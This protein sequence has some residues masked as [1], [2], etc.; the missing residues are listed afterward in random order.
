MRREQALRFPLISILFFLCI[1]VRTALVWNHPDPSW[2]ADWSQAEIP[3]GIL[4][5]SPMDR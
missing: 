1:F 5:A 4:L 3:G 2:A